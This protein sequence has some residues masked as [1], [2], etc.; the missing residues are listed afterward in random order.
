MC[1]VKEKFYILQIMKVSIL[2]CLN[3]NLKGFNF[4][5]P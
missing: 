1:E 2:G 4:T 5:Y 3:Q